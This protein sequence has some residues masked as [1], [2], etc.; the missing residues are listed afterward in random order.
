MHGAQLFAGPAVVCCGRRV[1]IHQRP[2][3]GVDQQHDGVVVFKQASVF[4][5]AHR[6]GRRAGLD[7]VFQAAPPVGHEGDERGD[8]GGQNDA[9]CPHGVGRPEGPFCDPGGR[10]MTH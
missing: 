9:A 6:K 3:F 5:L 10:R 7:L 1:G 4:I 2:A 8:Q